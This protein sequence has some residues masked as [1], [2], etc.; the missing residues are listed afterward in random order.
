VK[1]SPTAKR[2]CQKLSCPEK[3]TFSFSL[4][5]ISRGWVK[6][7]TGFII[8]LP[9]LCSAGISWGSRTFWYQTCRF[10][11]WNYAFYEQNWIC[12][13]AKKTKRKGS[14]FWNWQSWRS[15]LQLTKLYEREQFQREGDLPWDI[16]A[17]VSHKGKPASSKI[18]Q[19]SP[20]SAEDAHK[21]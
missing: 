21:W 1:P 14:S 4:E 5:S 15:Y 20:D 8:P 13:C 6:E 2:L 11:W 7:E 10:Y 9:G 3:K 17:W 19:Q 18:C 16:Q 12:I